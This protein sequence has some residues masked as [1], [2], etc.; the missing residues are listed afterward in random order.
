MKIATIFLLVCSSPSVSA[1]KTIPEDQ[2]R[3]AAYEHELKTKAVD[4]RPII[5]GP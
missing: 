2:A 4:F 3:W 5:F 1:C